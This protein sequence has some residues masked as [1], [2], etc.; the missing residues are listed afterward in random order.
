M[1]VEDMAMPLGEYRTPRQSEIDTSAKALLNGAI[2]ALLAEDTIHER[3]SQARGCLEKLGRF[4]GEADEEFVGELRCIIDDVEKKIIEGAGGVL[5]SED[6]QDLPE[7]LF[8]LYLDMSDG[9]MIW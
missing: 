4:N 3:V 7:R 6:E 5:S 2:Q 8:L 1:R 9:V